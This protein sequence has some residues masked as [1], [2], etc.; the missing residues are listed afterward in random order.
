MWVIGGCRVYGGSGNN[1]NDVW[2]SF[3]G[4]DW[5]EATDSAPWSERGGHAVVVFNNEL[6]VLGGFCDGPGGT[7]EPLNDV[8]HSTDGVSWARATDSADWAP[9]GGHAA[10][11][12][13]G[14]MWVLGGYSD[15]GL[16]DVWWSTDGVSWREAT[17]S[18]PWAQRTY[19]AAVV[20]DSSIWVLGG[21]FSGSSDDV[22]YSL[23]GVV[24]TEATAS[25]GWSGRA[26]HTAV[27][28]DGKIWVMGGM[29]NDQALRLNDVWYS[30]NGVGWTSATDSAE[31]RPR[32]WHTSVVYNNKLWVM[33]GDSAINSLTMNDVWSSPGLGIEETPDGEVLTTNSGPT[34][35]RSV[36]ETGAQLAASGA[37]LELLDAAGRR[38]A[39]LH[40]GPN[41][42][43]RLSPGIY[44]VQRETPDC[45]KTRKIV[46]TR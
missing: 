11:V 44:F 24:W 6:W 30:T 2:Y 32:G 28:F 17:D 40:V 18:A 8:W 38:V 3:N 35:V 16:N 5:T 37:R 39:D 45:W 14:R 15:R 13:D 9:R 1:E 25:A 31:W 21:L 20:F 27:A 34:I 26:G 36:L 7:P 23:D 22:W 12:L 4:T 46:I 42:V 19:L 29:P 43:S 10:V 41:D 33:G